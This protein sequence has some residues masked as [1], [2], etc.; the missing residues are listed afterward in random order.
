MHPEAGH[1]RVA[2]LSGDEF[3]GCCPFHGACIE[4]LCASGAVAARK[5]CTIQELPQ[6][7]DEDD[8]WYY[9]ELIICSPPF[10]CEE[11]QCE[12]H[13]FV[14]STGISALTTLPS[15]VQI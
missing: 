4:G 12:I 7:S 15:C 13:L 6:L 1:I 2:K 11:L 8:V 9:N 5:E 10:Q 14:L 3:P